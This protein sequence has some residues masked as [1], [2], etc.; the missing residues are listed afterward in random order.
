[1]KTI[2]TLLICLLSASVNAQIL[3][4]F[5]HYEKYAAVFTSADSSRTLQVDTRNLKTNTT[6]LKTIYFLGSYP[7]SEQILERGFGRLIK[8]KMANHKLIKIERDAIAREVGIW[9]ESYSMYN[10]P[11]S[12]Y[13]S[14]EVDPN[15]STPG[16]KNAIPG[17]DDVA[18]VVGIPGKRSS[19]PYVHLKVQRMTGSKGRLAALRQDTAQMRRRIRNLMA[20]SLS[21]VQL[22]KAITHENEHLSAE[23]SKVSDFFKVATFIL[24]ILT[25]LGIPKCIERWRERRSWR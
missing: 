4:F 7:I 13:S 6:L 12:H 16:I 20:D 10:I 14:N 3:Y 18:A 1:M 5:D 21:N 2:I 8:Y 9:S 25:F 22:I 11:R 17:K 24:T 23:L 19:K 15:Q